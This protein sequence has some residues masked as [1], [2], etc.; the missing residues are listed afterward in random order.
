M[1]GSP[2]NYRHEEWVAGHGD[3]LKHV[4]FTTVI[5]E[6]QA[7]HPAGILL[8][9]CHA[10]E[11]VYDLNQ[12]IQAES[13]RKG[14]LKLMEHCEQDPEKNAPTAVKDFVELVVAITGCT[15]STDLDVYPG[16]PVLGQHLLRSVDE[17][18]LTDLYVEQVQWLTAE[19]SDFRPLRDTYA[20]ET[21]EFLMPYTYEGKHPVILID[22]DYTV[23]SDYANTKTLLAIILDQ[24][25]H[26]TVIVPVPLLQNHTLRWSYTA[27][28]RTVAKDAAQTGRY[29]CSVQVCK[30]GY[31]GSG[32][33]VC[34]PTADLD[35]V[36]LDAH[37]LHWLAHAMQ[38]GKDECSWNRP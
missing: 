25:P 16:S 19:R 6:L 12:H 33:L 13:Y 36:K 10:G 1:N 31:Q 14:I 34:N 18:R 23:E 5:R 9:N 3:V 38:M 27:G 26:A 24:N 30:D 11:G 17:H 8:V 20:A 29:Y 28:L 7:Q 21:M 4:V 35:T 2:Y 15:G 37:C 22:P 32:V